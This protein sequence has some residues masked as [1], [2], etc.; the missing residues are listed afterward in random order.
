MKKTII[1]ALI[2]LMAMPSD[3]LAWGQKG[4]RIVAEVAYQTMKASTRK[5]VDAVL[6]RH[7]IVYVAN[8]P[9]EIKSDTIYPMS[10]NWHFQDMDAGMSDSAVVSTL[11]NYPDAKTGRLWAVSDSLTAV[12]KQNPNDVD[13]LMFMV[14]FMGDRFCPMHTAHLSDKGGNAVKMKFFGKQT[15]L[16]SIWDSGIIDSRGYDYTEYAQFLIDRYGKKEAK[17]IRAMSVEELTV[18][19]YHTVNAI[20]DYQ[21]TWNGNPYHY[22]Y[23]WKD[24]ME[25]NLYA[26][27]IRLAQLLEEIYR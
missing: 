2:A 22:V 14:H 8:W 24:T 15:N 23:H 13:A 3:L 12:L 18:R 5:K 16:H 20:Y 1:L 7:G 27:G 4:H 25:W 26:A 10:G 6:G 19:N 9:D 21:Q 17:A 11:T